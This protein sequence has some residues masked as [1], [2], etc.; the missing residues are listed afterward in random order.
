MLENVGWWGITASCYP[1]PTNDFSR[2]QIVSSRHMD[3]E[4]KEAGYKRRQNTIGLASQYVDTLL[5]SDRT[6]EQHLC[7]AFHL[8]VTLVHEIGHLVYWQNLR[9]ELLLRDLSLR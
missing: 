3:D 9:N 6:S 2:R 8:V 5:N 7:A 4:L 1:R